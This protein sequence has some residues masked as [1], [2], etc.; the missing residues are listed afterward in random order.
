MAS[1]LSGLALEGFIRSG[2]AFISFDEP[3]QFLTRLKVCHRNR[4]RFSALSGPLFNYCSMSILE[5]CA[6][7]SRWGAVWDTEHH[8]S[9]MYVKYRY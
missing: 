8:K 2:Q 3:S 4:L 5:V 6:M 7:D 1:I 9:S